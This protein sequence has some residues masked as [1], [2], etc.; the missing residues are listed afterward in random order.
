MKYQILISSHRAS[1]KIVGGVG[2]TLIAFKEKSIFFYSKSYFMSFQYFARDDGCTISNGGYIHSARDDFYG[3]QKHHTKY[4][5]DSD[6]STL[7]VHRL[8]K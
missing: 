6:L 3:T 5:K 1:I 8:V 2:E 7:T 4:T